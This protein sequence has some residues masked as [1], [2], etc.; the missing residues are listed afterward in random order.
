MMPITLPGK[1][2]GSSV[3][4]FGPYTY[5]KDKR[6]KIPSYRCT[7]H[8]THHKCP[9]V[10][11]KENNNYVEKSRHNHPKPPNIEEKK[12]LHR[13]IDD[14]SIETNLSAKEIFNELRQ[15]AEKSQMRP[16][17]VKVRVSKK[18]IANLPVEPQYF[19]ELKNS[20][21]TY[22]K[23]SC[24][25]RGIIEAEDGSTAIMLCQEELMKHIGEVKEILIQQTYEVLFK[26]KF[27][28]LLALLINFI[29]SFIC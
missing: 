15:S 9:V 4:L 19:Y 24:L 13:M 1:F 12:K 6:C 11:K 22:K 18:R 14:G 25:F 26:I 16:S 23:T 3:Y 8:K 2:P 21:S 27:L 29:F 28:K 17:A 7:Y 10:I 20:I 5:H